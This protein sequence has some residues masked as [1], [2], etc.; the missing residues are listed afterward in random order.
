MLESRVCPAAAFSTAATYVSGL[1][2]Q[3]W[4]DYPGRRRGVAAASLVVNFGILL[5]FKYLDF[6]WQNLSALLGRLQISVPEKTLTL[7]LPV[8]IS[9]Y[10]FQAVGYTIDV[11]R[12]TVEAERNFGYYAL[13][14]SFSHSWWPG[15]SSVPGICCLR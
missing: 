6:V 8:G 13:F 4:R 5:V 10:V 9:F 7:L 2:L 3:R 12:G 11:Y 1:L 15:L 14:V